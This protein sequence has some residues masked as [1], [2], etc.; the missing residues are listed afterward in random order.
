MA[1]D[2]SPPSRSGPLHSIGNRALS[3]TLKPFTAAAGL[4]ADAGLEVENRALDRLLESGE[5]ERVLDNQR[6]QAMLAQLLAGPGARQLVDTLFDSGLIDHF[7]DRL[8][9]RPALW[10]LIDEIAGSP[11][12]LDAVS[13]QG[14]GFAD[15]VGEVVRSRSRRADDWLER[16]AHRVVGRRRPESPAA[17][18]TSSP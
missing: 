12:V 8:L 15:Q 7:L 5:L 1:D 11:A 13:N 9:E 2:R 14:L 18:E 4:A 3:A 6:L 17:P 16:A 10:H